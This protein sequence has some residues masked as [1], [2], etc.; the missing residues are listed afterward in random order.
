[1][2]DHEEERGMSLIELIIAMAIGAVVVLLAVAV[3]VNTLRSQATVTASTKAATQGQNVSE[4]IDGAVRTATT[5]GGSA[6]RLDACY[7]DDTWES[8]R[9][10]PVAG[11]LSHAT[12]ADPTSWAV[13]AD[14]VTGGSF[15][16]QGT[17]LTYRL[18]LAGVGGAGAVTID[19]TATQ[20]A[21]GTGSCTP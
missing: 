2:T 11:T 8:F 5:L 9:L 14:S 16:V 12:S 3:L 1:M 20:R 17:A 21:P 19:S 4:L 18:T 10:D 13:L 6:D 7:A 15:D